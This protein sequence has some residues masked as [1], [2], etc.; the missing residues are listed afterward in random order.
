MR[1]IAVL[2]LVVAWLALP[3]H[4]Q[5]PQADLVLRNGNGLTMVDPAARAEAI[6]ISDGR[7][8]AV[9]TEASVM[10]YRGEGTEVVDL[11]GRTFLPGFVDAHGHLLFNGIALGAA[12]LAPP[13]VGTATD[14]AGLVD[15]LSAYLAANDLGAGEWLIGIGYD[16]S[17]L[18]ERRHPTRDDLDRVS[19]DRPIMISHVSGHLGVMNSAALAAIGYDADTADPDGGIIRR[20]A[21]G[22]TPNGI[23]EENAFFAHGARIAPSDPAAL[24]AALAR[25]L[26]DYAAHGITTAQDG[27]MAIDQVALMRAAAAAGIFT[28]DVAGLVAMEDGG[29]ALDALGIGGGYSEGFRIAGVKL[30]LDGSP[31]GRTAWLRDPVPVPPDG[32]SQGYHGY[33]LIS[34]DALLGYLTRAAQ[35]DWRVYAH[36]NGDAAAQQLID[37]IAASGMAREAR[38]IA[39][40]NQ[41]VRP[42]Q[43]HRMAE[44]GIHPSFFAAHTF[45]WGDWHREAA[46]GPLRADFISPQR[47]AIDIGLTP[48]THNDSP[49][50]PPDV[51]RLIW[52]SVTRR[53]RTGDILGP[54]QRVTPYEALAMVTRNAAWQIG[55]EAEKGMLAPGMR[56]DIVVLSADPTAVAPDEIL[57]IEVVATLKDGATVFGSLVSTD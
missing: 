50:V 45:Y 8:V 35:N 16:D 5:L 47:T 19:A 57:E 33:G 22:S 24:M 11:E 49:V 7:I 6:A 36:V 25:G 3:A 4:A 48:S 41:V 13:P 54:G 53:T 37:G 14:I 51:M 10:A 2:L 39:I 42:E 21:D 15:S 18:A 20:E 44:L 9:G 12:N 23:L 28:I 27:R 1:G 43:L 55:E 40:H 26:A 38:T 31:Q 32:Q 29:E 30:V 17:L 56:A 46:L 34:D 52:S